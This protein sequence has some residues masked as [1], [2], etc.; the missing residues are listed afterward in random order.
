MP[1]MFPKFYTI[2]ITPYHGTI[3]YHVCT[4]YGMFRTC[5]LI[6]T[7]NIWVFNIRV[8]L[9]KNEGCSTCQKTK[10]DLSIHAKR[11]MQDDMKWEKDNCMNSR[12][13]HKLH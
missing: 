3:S 1:F 10:T 12:K 2:G 6:E 7:T 5:L 4:K 11:E 9:L 13:F 8:N